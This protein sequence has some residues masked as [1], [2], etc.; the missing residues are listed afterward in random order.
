MGRTT[1]DF[2]LSV[3][4]LAGVAFAGPGLAQT[5][6]AATSR[7]VE[8]LI[9]TAQK[10]EESAQDVPIS[11]TALSGEDLERRGVIGF[12]DLSTNVPSLRFGSGVTGG[13]NVITLRGI[14]SQNTTSGGDSPVAYNLDGVYLA[15]TTSVD[16]E[17]FDIDRIEVLRGPQGTLYG[18]NSVGGSINVITQHPQQTFGAHIDALGG[19]YNAQ[20]YRAWINAPLVNDG[21][22]QVLARVSAVSAQHD[23]FQKN[24]FNGPGA[25]HNADGQDF[26][27]V[28][29]ELYFKI[30]EAADFL[31][32]GS[33]S[34]N[35][36]PVATKTW[37][38]EAPGRYTGALPF[39]T[40]PRKIRK[41]TPENFDQDGRYV[42][43]TFNYDF[44]PV[45]LTSVTG[46]ASG[47][48]RQSN[49][50]DGSELTIALNPDWTLDQWQ[51]SQE[52]RLA[53]NPSDR[54][55]SWIVGAFYFREK[56]GQTFQ[57]IDTGLN[58]PSPF[59][60]T[61]IF[62]NGGIYKTESEAVFGQVDYDLGKSGVGIP[63]TITLGFRYTWDNKRGFDFLN[64]NLPLVP[65]VSEPSKTFDKSW[66]QGTGKLGAKYQVNR[67]VMVYASASTGYLSGGGLVGNFP[68]IYQP[69][70]VK[71]YEAGFKTS[72]ADNRMSF[73]GAVYRME[74]S[75][76]QV[77]VQ[78]ITGSRIDN[79]GK[80]HV[81]GVE[82]EAVA[83]PTDGLQLNAAATFTKA[84][85]DRYVTIDN[86]FAN[87]APGCD[88]VTRLCNFAG[89]R[90]VQTP[91]YTVNLGAQYEIQTGFGTVTPRVDVFW[92]GDLFFLSA[93]SPLDR[94]KAYALVD[95][96]VI[97]RSPDR[98]WSVEGFVHNAADET[99]I[100]ND[101]LQSNTIGNGFGLDNYTYYP[102]RTY[103]VRVGVNF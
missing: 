51:W 2:L 17:F 43:G 50:P 64:F 56:V 91:E 11:L 93:N 95:A 80:A 18:R 60:D 69:E 5:R 70:K 40:D 19:N 30:S 94:Q 53:S 35:G 34:W 14:G 66:T 42:S 77:F 13:E 101:G 38:I 59:T 102:P 33:A 61:F 27:M 7:T 1:R 54:A 98:R 12:Q 63:L 89:H 44:G 15:R 65:F 39:L 67:D 99:V 58:S 4:A 57:F 46:Y 36:D 37:W 24:L 90:L 72:L 48:W 26:W 68:G 3:S 22:H 29:G 45:T 85:Y 55:L 84:E 62:T 86:R 88:P 32:I 49:D 21:D 82:L 8:E 100:S 41:N 6:P 9:V 52:I 10:R 25:T 47:K 31:L 23:A 73:N 16:P 79:A 78:D 81:N 71:A 76:M 28:R 87:A 96:N 92:S 83:T 103:G 20:I 97:W 74:I 75:N